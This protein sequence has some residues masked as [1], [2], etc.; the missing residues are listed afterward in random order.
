MLLFTYRLKCSK[1]KS[2]IGI[3]WMD[4]WTHLC[5]TAKKWLIV[6]NFCPPEVFL[7]VFH[8]KEGVL[9]WSVHCWK[10]NMFVAPI[11][12]SSPS[13]PNFPNLSAGERVAASSRSLACQNAS[14]TNSSGACSDD[15]ILLADSWGRQLDPGPNCPGPG[16]PLCWGGQLGYGQM[17]PGAQL[18]GA[19]LSTAQMSEAQFAENPAVSVL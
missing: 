1:A 3:G 19:R 6:L 12:G 2:G 4:L 8:K 14:E 5:Y 13:V 7:R 18:S 9:L 16:C 11:K 17:G 10:I 15:T